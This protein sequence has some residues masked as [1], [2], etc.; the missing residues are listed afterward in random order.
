MKKLTIRELK[1]RK[2]KGQITIVNAPD[3]NTACACAQAGVDIIVIGRR[4]AVEAT[5]TVLP[6]IRR[7]VP[8]ILITAVMP[9]ESCKVSDE[10]AIRDA[11]RLMEGGA[12]LVYTTGALPDRI[13]QMTRQYIP[14]VSHL[15]L[16]PYQCT[17][18]GGFCAVGKTVD[19]AKWLYDLAL[20]LDDAGVICA[21][22]ECIPHRLA[23]Y[24]SSQV[25][26]LCYS[27]GSGA[28]C[29]GQYLFACDLLGSH[30]GHY[31]RHSKRY[32]D[33]Y[34]R[35]VEIFQT[36]IQEVN[37]G[38]YPEEKHLIEMPEEEYAAFMK[39]IRLV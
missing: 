4:Q 1:E 17:W 29:D 24:I 38:A 13:K 5:M 34:G 15:G 39:S 23:S 36:F 35:S 9:I 6:D 2:G 28:G 14:C 25:N 11:V 12:D 10:A 16:I 31:P 8:D 27:M 21:E 37:T 22:L 7:A 32:G 3:V 26:F 19:Q 30:T 33:F 18:T 20:K